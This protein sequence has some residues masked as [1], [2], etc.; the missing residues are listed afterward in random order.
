MA[1]KRVVAGTAKVTL[2]EANPS[3]TALLISNTH[4]TA[5]AYV[6]DDSD[7]TAVTGFPIFSQQSVLLTVM[8][9]VDITKRIIVISDTATTNM[10]VWESQTPIV[11]VL[12][13]DIQ[14]PSTKDPPM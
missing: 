13:P 4:A 9:G 1:T 2:V 11:I 6:T 7:V 10:Q 8:D 3:R 5:I 14:D 12:K